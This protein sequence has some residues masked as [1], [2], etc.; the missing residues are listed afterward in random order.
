MAAQAFT[1]THVRACDDVNICHVAD[2]LLNFIIRRE[3]FGGGER[4]LCREDSSGE[5]RA[6]M[7]GSIQV[8]ICL[9][10]SI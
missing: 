3:F 6:W 1:R 5:A 7:F 2:L 8:F 4:D 9:H 10:K